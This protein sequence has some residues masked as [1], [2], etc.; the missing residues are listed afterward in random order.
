M[1]RVPLSKDLDRI[2]GFYCDSAGQSLLPSD[3][4][5][6]IGGRICVAQGLS[7]ILMHSKAGLRIAGWAKMGP[8][9]G[10][11]KFCANCD[12]LFVLTV[13]GC[14]MNANGQAV[15]RGAKRQ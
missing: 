5:D 7:D 8:R 14:K 4:F 11:L 1:G 12:Q 13:R 3:C 10:M 15:R 6:H 9:G 2:A